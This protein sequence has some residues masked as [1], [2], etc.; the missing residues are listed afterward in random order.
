MSFVSEGDIGAAYPAPSIMNVI[1]R[2]VARYSASAAIAWISHRE[3]VKLQHYD[4]LVDPTS[5]SAAPSLK[6][7]L[8]V[9]CH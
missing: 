8:V 9:G 6:K 1:A 2:A 7:I 5:L 4:H 3:V